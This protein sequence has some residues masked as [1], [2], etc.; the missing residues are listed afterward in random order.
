MD[1]KYDVYE[2]KKDGTIYTILIANVYYC[3]S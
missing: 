2:K 3:R 1:T